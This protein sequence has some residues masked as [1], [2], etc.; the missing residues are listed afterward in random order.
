LLHTFTL[1]QRALWTTCYE[2]DTIDVSQL[3]F[4]RDAYTPSCNPNMVDCGVVG[5][6]AAYNLNPLDEAEWSLASTME[7]T[8]RTLFDIQDWNVQYDLGTFYT[9]SK[10]NEWCDFNALHDD[11]QGPNPEWFVDLSDGYQLSDYDNTNDLQDYIDETWDD[12]KSKQSA[13]DI[14][15]DEI[16][17][18]VES[19]SCKYHR[20]KSENSC[21]D[22]LDDVMNNQEYETCASRNIFKQEDVT[23][24]DMLQFDGVKENECL[25]KRRKQLYPVASVYGDSM[26]LCNG[27]YDYKC[28]E[29]THPALDEHE[30]ATNGKL[31]LVSSYNS[32]GYNYMILISIIVFGMI[33]LC[34]VGINWVFT[35][36][37]SSNN[38]QSHA[39]TSKQSEEYG[40][41]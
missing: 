40:T 31:K 14:S 11:L 23:L 7:I 9:K 38:V 29:W 25:M 30:L 36:N 15:N 5:V 35:K 10:L 24:D 21:Y 16:Y 13:L 19:L 20:S 34:F 4:Y 32:N 1:Y 2:Y 26:K 12:L 8:P 18:A 22:I 27:E 33:A 37:E 39:E 28:P 3:Q 17:F 6:D 41:F